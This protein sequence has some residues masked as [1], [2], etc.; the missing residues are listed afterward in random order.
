MVIYESEDQSVWRVE[1]ALRS[2]YHITTRRAYTH[3]KA[4]SLFSFFSSETF[5]S[6]TN[7][8]S[9]SWLNAARVSPDTSRLL[10]A[11]HHSIHQRTSR[12][13][14][15]TTI[16]PKNTHITDSISNQSLVI[17]LQTLPEGPSILWRGW[18]RRQTYVLSVDSKCRCTL[19]RHV[20]KRQRRGPRWSSSSH[21]ILCKSGR[22][23]QVNRTSDNILGQ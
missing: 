1:Q 5:V 17:N 14:V 13:N 7:D 15:M 12:S 2:Q 10:K 9:I 4:G 8:S 22:T 19:G 11:R 16:Y 6:Q 18:L 23:G 3:L 20:A 21:D